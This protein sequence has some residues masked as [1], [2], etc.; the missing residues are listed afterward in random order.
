[1]KNN[2]N[3]LFDNK[4][5]EIAVNNKLKLNELRVGDVFN[6]TTGGSI[7]IIRI[8]NYKKILIRHNDNN[9][10]ETF[11][12]L[13]HI[14][15]GNISNPYFPSVQ[16]RGYVGVGDY[17]VNTKEYTTWCHMFTRCYS[18]KYHDKN[19]TYVDCEVCDEWLNFQTFA[20]WYCNTGYYDTDYHLDKDLLDY[21]NRIYSPTTCCVIPLVINIAIQNKKYNR[22]LPT[23]V[24]ASG[25]KFIAQVNNSLSKPYLGMYTTI[26]EARVSYI[27]AKRNHIKNLADIW[28]NR[29]PVQTYNALMKYIDYI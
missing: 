3:R 26:E 21:G 28:R 29:I 19:P 25:N 22:T 9:S 18:T 24:Y 6:I 27:L 16:G 15:S 4:I 2:P 23:G 11:T 8:D 7:T 12:R 10:H 1:M 13:S 20:E 5:R 14:Q 17:R